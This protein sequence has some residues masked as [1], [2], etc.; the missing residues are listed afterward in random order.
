MSFCKAEQLATDNKR[1]MRKKTIKFIK[2]WNC[3]LNESWGGRFFIEVKSIHYFFFNNHE[4]NLF[5]N[6]LIKDKKTNKISPI[7]IIN[8]WSIESQLPK[9]I[10]T[11]IVKDLDIYDI[12]KEA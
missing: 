11:A 7:Y 12:Y 3:W 10:N 5:A 4:T 1:K 2:R 6:I 8:F 9:I